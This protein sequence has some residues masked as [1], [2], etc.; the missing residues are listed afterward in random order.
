MSVVDDI[1]EYCPS[2]AAQYGEMFVPICM[3]EVKSQNPDVR[4]SAVFGLL[5]CSRCTDLLF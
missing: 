4:Q 2:A 1:I 5:F 3:R